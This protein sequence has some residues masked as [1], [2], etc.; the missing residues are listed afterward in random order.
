MQMLRKAGYLLPRRR[1]QADLAIMRWK[2]TLQ[3]VALSRRQCLGR[4]A[5]D[6]GLR[7]LRY[8]RKSLQSTMTRRSSL[9]MTRRRWALVNFHTVD[10]AREAVSLP[11]RLIN[12]WNER[13]KRWKSGIVD[14]KSVSMEL[15]MLPLDSRWIPLWSLR[16]LL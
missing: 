10:Q 6:L 13:C 4:R 15:K 16:P 3:Q 11:L 12:M 9:M 2:Q 8:T 1:D 7:C 5:I 14:N